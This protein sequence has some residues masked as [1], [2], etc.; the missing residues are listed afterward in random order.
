VRRVVLDLP[1]LYHSRIYTKVIS[2]EDIYQSD[3][4]CLYPLFKHDVLSYVFH[5]LCGIS[6]AIKHQWIFNLYMNPLNGIW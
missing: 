5:K 3:I 2:L 1:V 6:C 4:Q